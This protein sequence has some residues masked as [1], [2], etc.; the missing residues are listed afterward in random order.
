MA[1]LSMK[2]LLEAGAAMRVA[3]S[4]ELEDAVRRLFADPELRDRMGR[5]SRDLVSSGQGALERTL[6]IAAELLT[7]AAG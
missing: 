5:A 4:E 7:P 1:I 2:Q 3:G 6:E